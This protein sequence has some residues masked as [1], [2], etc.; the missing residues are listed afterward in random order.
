ML[1][2]ELLRRCFAAHAP[3]SPRLELSADR[4]NLHQVLAAMPQGVLSLRPVCHRHVVA[5]IYVFSETD[6]SRNVS[7][8]LCL[9]TIS[10]ARRCCRFWGETERH[11]RFAMLA[12]ELL[13][14]CCAHVDPQIRTARC[15][16]CQTGSM[17]ALLE[18]CFCPRCSP[19]C[20]EKLHTVD[21][22]PGLSRV[23]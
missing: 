16:A 1:C 5:Y 19:Q 11:C 22:L 20:I 12:K 18:A 2:S 13:C 23:V 8:A 9:R 4:I 14:G 6:G 3:A 15:S 7:L 17:C 10:T 21:I